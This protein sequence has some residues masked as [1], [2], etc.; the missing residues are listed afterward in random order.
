MAGKRITILAIDDDPS[1]IELL[2]EYLEAI[3]DWDVELLAYTDPGPARAELGRGEVDVIIS[4][5]MLGAETGL[6]MLRKIREAGDATPVI[7]LTGRATKRWP[8]K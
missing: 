7:V 2:R 3:P 8:S 4:D 1:D 5:Y 6:E